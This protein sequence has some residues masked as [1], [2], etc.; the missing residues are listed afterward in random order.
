MNL[1]YRWAVRRNGVLLTRTLTQSK[2]RKIANQFPGADISPEFYA[3]PCCHDAP[4]GGA[5]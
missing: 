5:Q 2:A 1:T 3:G 4:I